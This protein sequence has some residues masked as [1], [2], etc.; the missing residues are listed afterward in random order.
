MQN[1]LQGAK[2]E[3]LRLRRENEILGAQAAVVEV[4]AAVLGLRRANNTASPDIVHELQKAIDRLNAPQEKEP[5]PTDN[6][7][8]KQPGRMDR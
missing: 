2:L 8:R 7:G 1:A 3:I 6:Y 4:F 5:C